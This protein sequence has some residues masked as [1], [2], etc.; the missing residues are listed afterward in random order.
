[1]TQPLE[2]IHN[3]VSGKIRTP[4]LSGGEYF[5]TFTDDYTHNVWVYILKHKRVKYFPNFWR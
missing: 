3:D 4:S 2:L 5:V 1:M